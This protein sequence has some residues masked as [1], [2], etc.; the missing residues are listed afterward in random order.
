MNL[1]HLKNLDPS[2]R[3]LVLRRPVIRDRFFRSDR[4]RRRFL[5]TLSD[6][7]TFHLF[8]AA[9]GEIDEVILRPP[10]T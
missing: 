7:I 8:R 4:L 10:A 1:W 9:A 2:V 5:D 3:G 6:K